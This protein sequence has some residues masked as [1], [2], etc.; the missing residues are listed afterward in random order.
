[1]FFAPKLHPVTQSPQRRSEAARL[2]YEQVVDDRS[3][4][5]RAA[6]NDVR[7]RTTSRRPE[8]DIPPF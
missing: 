8:G 1:M 6:L 4:T 2:G 3:K 5:L 7:A